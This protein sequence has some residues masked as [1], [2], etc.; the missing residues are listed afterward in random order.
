MKVAIT[1]FSSDC[2]A[3]FP[4]CF[5]FKLCYLFPSYSFCLYSSQYALISFLSL[6]NVIFFVPED[7]NENCS[8][9]F[10]VSENYFFHIKF[11]RHI[12]NFSHFYY[13][14]YC[15]C[16]CCYNYYYF[17][18]FHLLF[19]LYLTLITSIF[20]CLNYTSLLL[21]LIITQLGNTFYNNYIISICPRQLL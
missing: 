4:I 9:N 11:K 10:F 14:C 20:Y 1:K 15:C 12:Y 16:C 5:S 19:S 17:F 13:Y 2:T 8:I 3:S 6:I 18:L 7:S 21:H